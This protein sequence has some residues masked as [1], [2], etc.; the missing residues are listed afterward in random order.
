MELLVIIIILSLILVVFH[1]V[2]PEPVFRS[3]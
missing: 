2:C 3:L 1:L